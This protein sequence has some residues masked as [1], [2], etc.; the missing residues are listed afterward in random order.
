M[1]FPEE[2]VGS[3]VLTKR[4][5]TTCTAHMPRIKPD[6]SADNHM[7]MQCYAIPPVK[8]LPFILI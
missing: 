8:K 7:L 3:L 5:I 2:N 6:E 4:N 1:D